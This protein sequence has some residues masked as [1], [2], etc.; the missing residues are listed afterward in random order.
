MQKIFTKMLPFQ[1]FHCRRGGAGGWERLHL[2]RVRPCPCVKSVMIASLLTSTRH[3][4]S[5]NNVQ[6]AQP[7]PAFEDLIPCERLFITVMIAG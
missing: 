1:S 6:R 7:C 2:A 4:R 5:G 3:K